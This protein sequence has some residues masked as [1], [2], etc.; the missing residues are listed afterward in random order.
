MEALPVPAWSAHHV[1]IRKYIP[2]R[3]MVFPRK[4]SAPVGVNCVSRGRIIVTPE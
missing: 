4:Y 3:I 2:G 1:R